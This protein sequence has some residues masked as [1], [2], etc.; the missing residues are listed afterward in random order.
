MEFS[1]IVCCYRGRNTIERC[2][3]SLTDQEFSKEEY[4]IVVVDDGST[5]GSARIIEDFVQERSGAP[6]LLQHFQKR[7]EGLSVARNFGFRR[8]KGR[9]VVYID[10]DAVASPR[11]LQALKKAYSHNPSADCVGGRVDLLNKDDHV[12]KL[13]DSSVFGWYLESDTAII[14]TNMSFKREFLVQSGGFVESFDRRGDESALFAKLRGMVT[15]AKCDEAIVLHSLPSSRSGWF[16]KRIE[17]GMAEAQ[18][19]VAF[20]KPK[21]GRFLTLIKTFGRILH[22]VLPIIS[23]PLLVLDV[24]LGA[25]SL[26][27]YGAIFW[28]RHVHSR[29]LVG[30]LAHMRS[31]GQKMSLWDYL[32]V[33]SLVFVGGWYADL[34]Y[35][36][37]ILKSKR[38]V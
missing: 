3:R 22:I 30:P 5:D 24:W 14:G 15:V 20:P 10:E 27:V 25:L 32:D 1:I 34:G 26:A 23:I 16:R 33:F 28:K 36:Y 19:D 17:N 12:A 4:E 11:Y 7:N 18:I 8:A 9:I 21:S 29:M 38:R 35:V 37:G 6:P 13:L 31:K 2:L